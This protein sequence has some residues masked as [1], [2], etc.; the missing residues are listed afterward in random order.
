[1]T[2]R[3][4]SDWVDRCLDLSVYVCSVL[5]AFGAGVLTPFLLCWF[6]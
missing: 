3:I 2:M 6:R 4:V 5:M 1:M